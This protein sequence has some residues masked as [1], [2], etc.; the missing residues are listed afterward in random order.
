M[1]GGDAGEERCAARIVEHS[2]GGLHQV[3]GQLLRRHHGLARGVGDDRRIVRSPAEH[4]GVVRPRHVVCR[5]GIETD[6]ADRH[7]MGA[8]AELAQHRGQ[9]HGTTGRVC[10]E[11]LGAH[12]GVET[13]TVGIGGVVHG[14]GGFDEGTEAGD[15]GEPCTPVGGAALE[16]RGTGGARRTLGLRGLPRAGNDGGVEVSEVGG[17]GAAVAVTQ[18]TAAAEHVEL[19]PVQTEPGSHRTGRRVEVVAVTGVTDEETG[20]FHECIEAHVTT[21]P[22][23]FADHFSRTGEPARQTVSV[24]FS[25]LLGLLATALS[26]LFVWPQVFRVYR[27]NIV[28]GIAP[29]GV[30]QGVSGSILWFTYG[31]SIGDLAVFGSNF[32]L[33]IAVGAVGLALVRHGG[34]P[35]SRLFGTAAAVLGFAF[36]CATFSETLVGLVAF[37]VGAA[38]ILP[39]TF[40]AARQPD[41]RGVSVP[42]NALLFGATVAWF[43][44]G[45]AV[46]DL[47]VM[48]PNLLVMPC[49]AF[50]VVKAAASQRSLPPVTA[51]VA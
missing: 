29:L 18:R 4:R 31:L 15:V 44:Y 40:L 5:L 6:G 35:A 11:R 14:I 9:L 23:G 32:M 10:D 43:S 26:M 36:V 48:A 46:G 25:D 3:V 21:L 30:L 41:L 17:N 47:L 19:H 13:E 12:G 2:V 8:A 28:E 1:H 50:I 20:V 49:S 22:A 7:E 42:S 34:L 45:L 51:D 37:I 38:S 27:R 16:V 39:Q 33:S 24:N